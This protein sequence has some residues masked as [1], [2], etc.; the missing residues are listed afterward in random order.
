MIDGNITP[1]QTWQTWWGFP[2]W[3]ET[4]SQHWN[5]PTKQVNDASGFGANLAAF[6]Q[7]NGLTPRP[8]GTVPVVSD[9][10]LLPWMGVPNTVA[11]GGTFPS[12]YDFSIIRR[13]PQLFSDAQA[14]SGT[15]S[16]FLGTW[17]RSSMNV[18][19]ARE[20]DLVMT[21]VRSFDVKAYDN[22]FGS[23]A[24]LGWGDDLRLYVPYQ[25]Q[26]GFNPQGLVLTTPPYLAQTPNVNGI[27]V[28]TIWPPLTTGSG[29]N[30]IGQTFAHEGRMPPIVNDLRFDAQWG[31]AVNYLPGGVNS[32]FLPTNNG[33]YNFG[34]IGDNAAGVVRMR[35]VWDSWSR[36]YS[37]APAKGLNVNTGYQT[38]PPYAPPIY[39]SY[40]APYPAP[41]R[42]IQI[43][44]RVADPTSQRIKSLTIRQDFSDKL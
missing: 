27:P 26:Q 39:P 6:G 37:V 3:R 13:T 14:Y 23:Y 28:P 21:N 11:Q 8:A 33:T 30:T 7:P 24:D 38:G 17:W 40:P 9:N 43:Q 5:D 15:M 18:A 44:I 29:Y 4:L 35:R 32:P 22:S 41:L 42:G 1:Q 25:N 10:Q 34:N 19:A 36:D 20:D 12:G 2:T 31:A 16:L